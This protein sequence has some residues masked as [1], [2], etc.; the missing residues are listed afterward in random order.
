MAAVGAGGALTL[1][2]L[3]LGWE[4]V[5]FQGITIAGDFLSPFLMPAL[6]IV[7]VYLYRAI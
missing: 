4:T 1:T 5:A 6:F 2:G 7:A 3:R